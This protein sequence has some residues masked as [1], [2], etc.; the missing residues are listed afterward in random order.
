MK[1]FLSQN[2]ASQ[3]LVS[4]LYHYRITKRYQTGEGILFNNSHNGF[5]FY[6]S[7]GD[8][9]MLLYSIS[10]LAWYISHYAGSIIASGGLE[11]N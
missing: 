5:R 1:Q 10:Y 2:Y 9:K 7:K 8:S 4:L 11:G 3:L 6:L